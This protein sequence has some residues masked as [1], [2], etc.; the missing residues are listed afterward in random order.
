MRNVYPSAAGFTPIGAP[1]ATTNALSSACLGAT[2][3]VRKD[4]LLISFA[5]NASKLYRLTAATWNDVSRVTGGAYNV[6]AGDRWKFSTWG[7]LGIATNYGDVVQKFDL[8]SGTNWTALLGSPP[9]AR[10]VD[11]V[12]DQIWLG[13]LPGYERRVHWSGVGLPEFWTPGTNNC[14]Y[15]DAFSGGPIKGIIGGA[16]AYVF[17]QQRVARA[18]FTPGSSTVYQ[19]DEL[20]G[21]RGLAAPHS[22]CR[23][24]D[25]AYYLSTDGFYKLDIT[26]GSTVP[27]GNNKWRQYFLNDLRA[28]TQLSVLGAADPLNPI[29]LW[30]YIS[31]DNSGQTPD[32]MVLYNWVLDEATIADINV[33]AL[34][35]WLTGGVTLDTMNSYGDLDHLPYSLDSPFWQGGSSVLGVF[36]TDHKLAYLQG[37]A[38]AAMFETSDGMSGTRMFVNGTEPL[39]DTAAATVAVSM[40]ERDGD[41]TGGAV[42]YGTFEGMEDTGIVPAHVSGNLARAKIIIPAA[43]S[44]TLMKGIQ[45]KARARGRR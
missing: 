26:S 19:F 33:E 4:G 5:G 3:I 42:V 2:T 45:T 12:R 13:A 17:Q 44:W 29:V 23:T 28:G 37:Q 14:D 16:Q 25:V 40:R 24:G 20:Q 27:I 9:N 31:R 39:V 1:I 21:G 34:A 6:A 38:L 35:S 10:Y 30:S 22:L 15:Q 41:A 36:G 43:A 8:V 18:T 11:I 32:R 7:D